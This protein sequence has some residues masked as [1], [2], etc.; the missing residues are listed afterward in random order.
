M[1]FC[2]TRGYTVRKLRP[3]QEHAVTTDYREA[4]TQQNALEKT[5]D[6]TRQKSLRHLREL[7]AL[8]EGTPI[9]GLMREL[10]R[11]DA[12]S[13]PLLALS[14]AWSRDP[15]L[16]ATTPAIFD[17]AEGD[18]VETASLADSVEKTFPNQYSELNRNKVARN[19][20]S[21]WTQSGHLSGRAKSSPPSP[22]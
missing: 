1:T 13:L 18:R 12:V 5:T 14:V 8:D 2:R 7:Y 3:L 21:S 22:S 20:S 10:H 4:I 11:M 15:L 16:R 9:F 19:A 6:S 17:A